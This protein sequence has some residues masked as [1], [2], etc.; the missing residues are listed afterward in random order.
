M[1]FECTQ[2][3]TDEQPATEPRRERVEAVADGRLHELQHQAVHVRQ[4]DRVELLAALEFP[5]ERVRVD[6][7]GGGG[8]LHHHLVGR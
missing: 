7:V 4:R 2:A 3:A 5:S 6:A 1:V 8:D